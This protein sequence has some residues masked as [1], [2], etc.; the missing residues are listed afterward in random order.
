MK[1]RR[2]GSGT[3]RPTPPS[4]PSS[5]DPV[6]ME[7]FGPGG[8][9]RWSRSQ[10]EH[11][12]RRAVKPLPRTGRRS[13][14]PSAIRFAWLSAYGCGV[15]RRIEPIPRELA[16]AV[17]RRRQSLPD[18]PR[19]SRRP[20]VT[21]QAERS[22][23]GLGRRWW[24]SALYALRAGTRGHSHQLFGRCALRIWLRDRSESCVAAA[25]VFRSSAILAV[26]PT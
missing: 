26:R 7:K 24:S 1:K 22:S 15:S 16:F 23:R 12:H 4:A 9:A 11:P 6:R 3:C 14:G 13:G 25:A 5:D 10:D 21:A 18:A 8:A 19:P 17:R 2:P 20:H